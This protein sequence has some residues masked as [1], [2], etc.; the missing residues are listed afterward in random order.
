MYCPPV[1]SRSF[2]LSPS[3]LLSFSSSFYIPFS[4]SR[5]IV[6]MHPSTACPFSFLSSCMFNYLCIHPSIGLFPLLWVKAGILGLHG[7]TLF[8]SC[9][10]NTL[11]GKITA[12]S[13]VTLPHPRSLSPLLLSLFSSSLSLSLSTLAFLSSFCPS[14]CLLLSSCVSFVSPTTD[15]LN[16]F[17]SK[18][19]MVYTF[20]PDFFCCS[21]HVMSCHGAWFLHHLHSFSLCVSV[22]AFSS[23]P[24]FS[25]LIQPPSP[26]PLSSTT[27]S[28][29]LSSSSYSSCSLLPSHPTLHPLTFFSSFHLIEKR[30]QDNPAHCS[31]SLCPVTLLPSCTLL[32]LHNF[33]FLH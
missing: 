14:S 11:D 2:S 26:T 12:V 3:R 20:T 16:P 24:P 29:P 7:L 23:L 33:L 10:S 28:P 15:I 19:K 30:R 5:F 1:I 6:S 18:R 8:S 32:S 9:S 17:R 4:S 21:C 22:C 13:S 25:L 27:S 31:P